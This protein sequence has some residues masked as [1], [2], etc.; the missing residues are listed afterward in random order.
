MHYG[1]VMLSLAITCFI[2]AAG[3]AALALRDELI[4]A[5]FN[6]AVNTLTVGIVSYLIQVTR[7]LDKE[8]ANGGK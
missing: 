7:R 5:S 8:V 2:A 4:L 3:I 1:E 6:A